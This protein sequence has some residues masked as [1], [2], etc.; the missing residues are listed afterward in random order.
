MALNLSVEEIHDLMKMYHAEL[1]KMQFQR[2]Q[3]IAALSG[4]EARLKTFGSATAE[5]V[6]QVADYQPEVVA[7]VEV[8][9]KRGRKAG[10]KAKIKE[11]AEPKKRGR[12]PGLKAEKAEVETTAEPKKRGRK[13]GVKAEV[14]EAVVAAEPKKRGR[15]PGVKTEI[16][17]AV[18]AAEPKKRGRKPGFKAEVTEVAVA[19]EP[20]KR[21]R[22]PGFK[23]EMPEV[24]E[25]AATEP[26]TRGRK[27][28]FKA[29]DVPVTVEEPKKRGRKSAV[30]VEEAPAKRAGRAKGDLSE[31]D[32]IA[33][34][35][36]KASKEPI[37]R[38][39]I[40]EAFRA[41]VNAES[42]GWNENKLYQKTS[43]VLIK[44]VEGH[45][46]LEKVEI[47]GRGYAY[48]VL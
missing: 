42:L 20:K 39:V 41:K 35:I 10:A 48:K 37:T 6:E 23:A 4:L 11:L 31:W 27:P 43:S 47:K 2:E 22:K 32:Q 26:K 15:K 13:P 18:I 16:A 9:A 19:A 7:P 3:I 24:I 28:G 8:P 40:D 38:G 46:L 44:L 29:N 5:P 34:D 1:N 25:V 30:V 36:A 45:K 14:A 21:G 12:K 33:M 17:E